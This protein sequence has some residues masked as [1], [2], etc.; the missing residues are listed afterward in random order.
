MLLLCSSLLAAVAL[1]SGSGV[2]SS[3]PRSVQSD[4]C[5]VTNT[6]E[7][8]PPKD[9]TV[10]PFPF[11]AYHVN[12]DQSI[13]LK[14]RRWFAG[15]HDK[16]IWVRPRGTQLKVVGRRLD[17]EAPPL[18]VRIPCCY[19]SGFQVT[20]MTFPTEG[21]WEVQATAGDKAIRFVII[22]EPAKDS[23]AGGE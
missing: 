21:C 11:G 20:G 16:G 3:T 7:D 19:P 17:G 2:A 8:T 9:P 13:W 5:P 14:S 15:R 12:A 18:R 22:V 1:L 23:T 6:V 4:H 10:T